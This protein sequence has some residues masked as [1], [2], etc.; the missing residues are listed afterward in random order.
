ME[1]YAGFAL[2]G[3]LSLGLVLWSLHSIS[4]LILRHLRS[5]ESMRIE[6]LRLEREDHE[7]LE[8]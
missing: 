7:R 8:T 1:V 4:D 5:I 3:F 6:A 2:V